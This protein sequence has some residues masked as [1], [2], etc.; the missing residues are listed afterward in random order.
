MRFKQSL[1]RSGHRRGLFL[2][3][4]VKSCTA[5]MEACYIEAVII[6]VIGTAMERRQL[7]SAFG[8]LA[9]LPLAWPMAAL[10]QG[11]KLYPSAS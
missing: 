4:A 2:N 6:Q 7:L 1:T 8:G 3:A 10:G 5:D 11:P 9:V